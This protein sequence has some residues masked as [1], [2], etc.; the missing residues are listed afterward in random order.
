MVN[1]LKCL[2]I[3]FVLSIYC[4]YAHVHCVMLKLYNVLCTTQLC[5]HTQFLSGCK[6]L[7]SLFI[8]Q[9][10]WRWITGLIPHLLTGGRRWA[11]C[12]SCPIA[13]SRGTSVWTLWGYLLAL[14]FKVSPSTGSGRKREE[15]RERRK[16]EESGE[17]KEK[18]QQKSRVGKRWELYKTKGISTHYHTTMYKCSKHVI[19][20]LAHTNNISVPCKN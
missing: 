10:H 18:R 2:G 15:W 14:V 9:F 19:L 13:L 8:L 17:V 12:L 20:S 3:I 11:V 5:K 16:E 7:L 6:Y 1:G 4:T